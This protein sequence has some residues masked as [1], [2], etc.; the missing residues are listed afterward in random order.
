[1]KGGNKLQA[2]GWFLRRF[3]LA[4]ISYLSRTVVEGDDA[5]AELK[6]RAKYLFATCRVSA[7][8]NI[9]GVHR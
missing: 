5:P 1:M 6:W 4:D 8:L 3:E 9:S 2:K 7:R